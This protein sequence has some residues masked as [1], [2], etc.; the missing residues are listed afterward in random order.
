MV[1]IKIEGRNSIYKRIVFSTY[2][3]KIK[4]PEKD[5]T[6]RMVLKMAEQQWDFLGSTR[7]PFDILRRF[8]RSEMDETIKRRRCDIKSLENE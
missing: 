8:C 4:L 1:Y 6:M 5:K 2:F 7:K 3:V